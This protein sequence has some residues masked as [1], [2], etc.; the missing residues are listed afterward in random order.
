MK[1]LLDTHF[2]LWAAGEPDKLPPTALAV[3]EN[4]I[5]RCKPLGDCDQTET[6]PR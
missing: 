4:A 3:I 2:L 6:G 1:L 5:L